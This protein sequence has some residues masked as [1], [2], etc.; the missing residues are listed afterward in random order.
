M[1]GR[2]FLKAKVVIIVF[3]FWVLKVREGEKN[4]KS[5]ILLSVSSEIN[6]SEWEL[7]LNLSSSL[8]SCHLNQVLRSWH[9]GVN[10]SVGQLGAKAVVSA[11]PPT[12]SLHLRSK[13][14]QVKLVAHLAL[15]SLLG[16]NN[17]PAIWLVSCQPD[18]K[19]LLPLWI[20]C[21]PL[22]FLYL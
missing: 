18:V 12:P 3:C 22:S 9:S 14:H 2:W 15:L 17:L 5:W 6:S 4:F 21:H 11:V 20:M 10:S 16:V 13:G 1:N 7:C 19:L 8:L